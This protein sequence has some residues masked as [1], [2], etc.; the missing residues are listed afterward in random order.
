MGSRKQGVVDE[1]DGRAV[2]DDAQQQGPPQRGGKSLHGRGIPSDGWALGQGERINGEG[3]CCTSKVASVSAARCVM[4]GDSVHC[5]LAQP[6]RV[7]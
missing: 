6:G 7:G 2:D 5:L 3:G 4:D 1:E